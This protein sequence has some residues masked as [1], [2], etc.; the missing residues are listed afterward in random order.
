MKSRIVKKH[1][2]PAVMAAAFLC[3]SGCA[4]PEESPVTEMPDP[5]LP[6]KGY[7]T[8]TAVV[9]ENTM[10]SFELTEPEETEPPEADN[11]THTHIVNAQDVKLRKGRGTS[12]DI[13][14]KLDE[15]T[16][17]TVYSSE[18][19]WHKVKTADGAE[20]YISA[21]YVSTTAN[22]ISYGIVNKQ[23]VNLRKGPGTEHDS[24]G[25]L[26]KGTELTV[27]SLNNGWYKVKSAAGEGYIS[28]EFVSTANDFA[29]EEAAAETSES[30]DEPKK[31]ESSKDDEK[32]EATPKPTE[33]PKKKA[34]TP[35]SKNY[36]KVK[37]NFV[38]SD[39]IS[40]AT[41]T[42][43]GGGVSQSMFA[44]NAITVVNIWTRT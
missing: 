12:H 19:G 38:D 28:A 32:T 42:M 6:D 30:D 1:I 23:G 43:S 5:E 21:E 29:N 25:E 44:K 10:V 26:S 20:G 35:Y 3:C 18:G 8:L 16:E 37:V 22:G 4:K 11:I 7:I 36:T 15:G 9:D 33:K 2:L 14:T 24:L 31:T 41:S 39:P 17:V 27:Y 40:F 13:I 34:N